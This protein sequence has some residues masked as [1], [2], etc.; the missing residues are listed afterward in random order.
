MKVDREAVASLVSWFYLRASKHLSRRSQPQVLPQLWAMSMG[1]REQF[2][3]RDLCFRSDLRLVLPSP[4]CGP[5]RK[6]HGVSM[7]GC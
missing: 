2:I 1:P 7:T 6:V 5:I 4:Q 3:R